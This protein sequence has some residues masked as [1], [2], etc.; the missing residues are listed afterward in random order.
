MILFIT[1][2]WVLAKKAQDVRLNSEAFHQNLKRGNFFAHYNINFFD[3]VYCACFQY[4]FG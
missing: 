2:K 4:F 3:Y 1:S